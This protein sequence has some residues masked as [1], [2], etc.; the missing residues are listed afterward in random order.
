MNKIKENIAYHLPTEEQF[1]DFLLTA[2]M[3]GLKWDDGK[4]A[5]E[6]KYDFV[7]RYGSNTAIIYYNDTLY[8]EDVVA[9]RKQ[10]FTVEEWQ[11]TAKNRQEMEGLILNVFAKRFLLELVKLLNEE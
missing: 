4:S 6:T 10:G 7:E 3:Q 5:V 8:H 2:E 9:M 11:P 1:V